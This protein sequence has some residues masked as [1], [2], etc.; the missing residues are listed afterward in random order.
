MRSI[1]KFKL[2]LLPFLC[3]GQCIKSMSGVMADHSYLQDLRL[4][5]SV[6]HIVARCIQAL[7]G[8]V[9]QVIIGRLSPYS[10]T[11]VYSAF[12]DRSHRNSA[13]TKPPST[14]IIRH[15]GRRHLNPRIARKS[16]AVTLWKDIRHQQI[17]AH[18]RN[19]EVCQASA[20]DIVV[21]CMA[22]VVCIA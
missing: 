13:R 10:P 15:T 7:G 18:P 21:A 6:A 12:S 14:K 17:A 2:Q 3:V 1:G 9:S 11:P 19:V 4:P 22:A 16:P 5:V 8:D 20:E